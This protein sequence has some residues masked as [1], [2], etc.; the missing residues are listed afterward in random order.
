ME[1]VCEM[2]FLCAP[3]G[4]TPINI[5]CSVW[6]K[7]T[8]GGNFWSFYD[9]M[10]YEV[11]KMD[12]LIEKPEEL[13]QVKK[14]NSLITS[15]GRTTLLGSK[16]L[17]AAIVKVQDR[18]GHVISKKET[19]YYSALK[20]RTKVDY[21]KGLVAE[22]TDSQLRKIL[23]TKSGSYY[24]TIE[25][26][27]NSTDIDSFRYQWGIDIKDSRTGL[28]GFTEI[29]SCCVYD[30]KN[31]RLFIKFSNEDEVRK[32]IIELKSNYTLLNYSMMM[33][34][35]CIYAYRIY[36]LLLSRVGYQDG[37]THTTRQ[38]YSFNY[39]LSHLKY[40]LGILDIRK[41]GVSEEL[42][43]KNPDFTRIEEMSGQN[44]MP[45]YV[46][47]K[48]YCLDKAKKEIDALTDFIFDFEPVRQGRGGKVVSVDLMLT[49]KQKE[50][51]SMPAD[52]PDEAMID[53]VYDEVLDLFRGSIKFK[54]VKAICAAADYD[55]EKIKKAHQVME[56]A[57]SV[58]NIVGFMIKAIKE[59][60]DKPVSKSRTNKFGEF[61]Q[62][63]YDFDELE[64]T[65]IS[66]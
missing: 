34:F 43:R 20:S 10:D 14:S 47:F 27:L 21:T 31:N 15:L 42:Q 58:D 38:A 13:I 39:E 35:K 63:S 45:R 49:R 40:L 18:D 62:N 23:K 28:Y 33:E 9:T 5:L 2:E 12:S 4:K 54:D 32:E 48:R 46:D 65:L 60:W 56:N 50:K 17:L 26:L 57:T 44:A 61:E 53:E 16:V 6:S 30:K 22:F 1:S 24:D 11:K 41:P 52:K 25:K 37:T 8:K 59:D 66:N 51:S 36:E 64:K 19:E 55:V 3:I 7:T 29:I